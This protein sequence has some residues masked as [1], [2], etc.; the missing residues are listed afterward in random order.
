MEQ[1]EAAKMALLQLKLEQEEANKIALLDNFP[2]DGHYT[3]TN[4][5]LY[6]INAG[7]MAPVFRY[8][9]PVRC[10]TCGC[11][12]LLFHKSRLNLMT[13]L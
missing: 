12:D 9:G 10:R 7:Q 11:E 6:T 1:K 13:Y 5:P 2:L 8:A 4:G 3:D